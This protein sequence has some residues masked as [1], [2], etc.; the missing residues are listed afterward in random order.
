MDKKNN[1]IKTFKYIPDLN[2]KT[3]KHTWYATGIETKSGKFTVS[4]ELKCKRCNSL[5][6]YDI[7]TYKI[8]KNCWCSLPTYNNKRLNFK[9]AERVQSIINTMIGYNAEPINEIYIKHE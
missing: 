5:F 1:I 8:K 6:Y 7:R 9:Y 3:C 4:V 2:K